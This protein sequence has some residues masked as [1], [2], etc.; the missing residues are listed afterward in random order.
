MS[1]RVAPFATDTRVD[2]FALLQALALELPAILSLARARRLAVQVGPVFAE[3]PLRWFVL[4][5]D[6]EA[7]RERIASC[8]A[9]RLPLLL[10]VVWDD[11]DGGFVYDRWSARGRLC[12]NT[13]QGVTG[14][15]SGQLPAPVPPFD[16][17]V[18]L[19]LEVDFPGEPRHAGVTHADGP[20]WLVAQDGRLLAA[21]V[22]VARSVL[23]GMRQLVPG[24]VDDRDAGA[25]AKVPQQP[26]VIEGRQA[27]LDQAAEAEKRG[28][29]AS[30]SQLFVKATEIDRLD[31]VPWLRLAWFAA[32]RGDRDRAR[33]AFRRCVTLNPGEIAHLSDDDDLAF[34]REEPFFRE[35]YE[36][37]CD[38]D[39]GGGSGGDDD[40]DD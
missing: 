34:L 38:D 9:R 11:R 14:I 36:S 26:R 15:T 21:P 29:L 6:G 37:Q 1:T 24:R 35:L 40:D 27:L 39:D 4:W 17:A 3:L 30:A 12:L 16:S 7:P 18:D 10:S 8:L 25:G 19:G 28:D 13:W 2:D 5:G 22:K 23:H 31:E 33:D 32:A 20:G